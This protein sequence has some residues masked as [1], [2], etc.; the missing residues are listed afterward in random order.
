MKS[1]QQEQKIEIELDEHVLGGGLGGVNMGFGI[2]TSAFLGSGIK[3][4]MEYIN[5][6]LNLEQHK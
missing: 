4:Y 2:P 5:F 1:K 6:Q 3:P